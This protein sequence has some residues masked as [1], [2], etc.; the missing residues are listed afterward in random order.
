MKGKFRNLLVGLCG[1]LATLGLAVGVFAATPIMQASAETSAPTVTML[2]GASA[3]KT[4]G[5]P[6]IK[7][8]AKIDNYDKNYQ[9]GMLI[10]PEAAWHALEWDNDTDFIGF[11]NEEGYAYANA[12]CAP[13][14]TD[15]GDWQISF[16]LKNIHEGNYS[17]GFF[18]VAYV[19]NKEAGYTDSE[20]P[21]C[22]IYDYID[23]ADVDMVTN[24]RSIAYVAQMALK[25]ED[26][27]TQEQSNTLTSYAN[28]GLIIE[29][30]D[31]FSDNTIENGGSA[32]ATE[33]N[34]VARFDID[35]VA[36]GNSGETANSF[37]TKEAYA[38]GSEV[39]FKTFI[40]VD[41]VVGGW[42]S[43]CWTTNPSAVNIYAHAEGNGQSLPMTK[44]SWQD[45]SFTLPAG[46]PYYIYF[47]GAKG[48][49]GNYGENGE[50]YVYIDNFTVG[51]TTENFSANTSDWIFA[52]NTPTAVSSYEYQKANII[53]GETA[54]ELSAKIMVNNI[55]STANT[56]SFI[57]AEKYAGGTVTFDYYMSGN[58]NDKWW[59][60]NWTTSN[61]AANIYAFVEPTDT[62]KGVDLPRV[63]DSWQT[64]TVEVPAGNWYFYFAGAVGEWGEGYVLIDNLHIESADYTETF[65]FGLEDSIFKVNKA[66]AIV[67]GEGYVETVDTT[68]YMLVFDE[69]AIGGNEKIAMI[70]DKA[71]SGV[72]EITF[73]AM[74]LN[75][76]VST[77][78]GL[79]YT[80]DPTKFAYD[81]DSCGT[82]YI[83]CYT[84]RFCAL[85]ID[86]GVIYNYRLT[87]SGSSWTLYANDTSLDSGT[88]YEG[89]NYFYFMINPKKGTE[90]AFY[91]DDFSIT[92]ADGTETDTFANGRSALFVESATKNSDHGSSGMSF[93]ESAFGESGGGDAEELGEVALKMYFNNGDDGVRA[94]TSTAY[95]GGSTIQFKYYIQA[96]TATQWT[97]FI[98][99][100]DTSCDNYADTY[101]SF[102]NT[103]GAWVT[104]SYTLPSGGPYYL[105]FGFEC[106]NWKDSSGAPYIL[107]DDFTVNSEVE[108]F[109]YGVENSCFTILQ[110]NLAGNSGLGEGYIPP[111][112]EALGAK[113][114][115]DMISSTANTPSFITSEKYAGG[116][117]TLDYYMSCKT[118]NKW[119]TFNWTTN[120]TVANIY[121][122]VEPT[123][124]NN[125]VSLPVV[126]DSWQTAT[127]EVP[128][129]NW[130][131][132]F[133]GSVGDWGE[134][135]VI[136]DNFY[137]ESADYTETFNNGSYGIF[138]DNRDSKPDA[139]TLVE[140]KEEFLSGEY[141]MKYIF[142]ASGE[143]VSQVTK[144]AYA[145]GSTVSFKY[146][147][148]AGT[149]TKWWG[150]VW[151]TSNRGLDIYAAASNASAY[152]LS[153]TLGEWV[154]VSFTLPAGGPYYLYF[155]SEVG[156]WKLN[157][158][159]AYVLID[160]FKVGDETEDFNKVVDEWAFDVLVD[161]AV[162][163]SKLGEGY[164]E[165]DVEE[166][167]PEVSGNPYD[168]ETL[169]ASGSILAMLKNGGYAWIKTSGTLNATNIPT[170]MVFIEGS[171]SYTFNGEKEFAIWFGNE[172]YLYINAT[173]IALYNDTQKVNSISGSSAAKL[174]LSI[175]AY[176]LDENEEE[177]SSRLILK[178]DNG[179]YIGLGEI[180]EPQE[181]KIVALGGDGSLSLSDIE[182]ETYR[183]SVA[184]IPT[185]FS[186]ESINFTAYAFDSENMISEAG[187]QLLADAGF[188]KTLALLQGRLSTG[189]LHEQDIPNRAHVENL[190]AE[191]NADAMAAVELA[192]KYGLKH[193][194]LNSNLYN[195]ERNPKNYQWLDDFAELA[196]YTLSHAFA[197]H[198]L[199]DEPQ[200][201][202]WF[203]DDEL[204][205]LVNAYK[206][207]KAAFPNS[208]AFINLLP[209]S[210][211]QF[212][213]KESLYEDYI[214]EY[215]EKIALDY[216]G[217]P[218]TG[219]V[220]FDHYP[221]E[222]GG[223]TS[224]HLRNLE[225]IAEKC[226][227]N[228]LELRTYIK[229]SES[230]DSARD[231]RATESINDLYMQIYSALAYGSKEIIYY[232]F[233]DHTK[234]DG[235]VGDAVISGTTLNTMAPVYQYAKQAN[236]EVLAF[237]AAYMNFTWKSASFFGT[238]CKQSD[239]LKSK[240]GVYG[241]LS[242]VAANTGV[243]IG[244]FDD[245][246]SAYTYDA[247][248]GYMVVNYGD[249]Q[250]GTAESGI[251]LTFNGT[252]SRALVYE[253][254]KARVVNLA[255]N[256]LTLN[257][258]VG[259]GAF[260]I[261]LTN[262]Q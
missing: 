222:E 244:N 66:D 105:Y 243:L 2:A 98:W 51:S 25:Y 215:I 164:I 44:G 250:N 160:N 149:E 63:Q 19:T 207:Y 191:V 168:F 187:F 223:I 249:P 135:Y 143:T 181:I 193:Y 225:L 252:P 125:G 241:Y 92:Y 234:S 151:S 256:A 145:G 156:N 121:A 230:G 24:A 237:S 18:G 130:Y 220:S 47:A 23:Y 246:D 30:D 26:Y 248:Y 199:A 129:G 52:V 221:L 213:T 138:L 64:A 74:W 261:P 79:S 133:A 159:N 232:Q 15:N 12:I 203:T 107:I 150:I 173:E 120:N 97:R 153:A 155:G 93:A 109:N 5:E 55:S 65:N 161:G 172:Y 262:N 190:M 71:Y 162:E 211:A 91:L 178:L 69:G 4:P 81:S 80:T 45:V 171:L 100:T 126:Q 254:G 78:W 53:I 123:D 127:V 119:W 214:D 157:G 113:I 43:V 48:E 183:C 239:S 131:F 17:R 198:F 11:F 77:T 33:S 9:Y 147:I 134:G 46:G 206:A 28:A 154:D 212:S 36:D 87:I 196:T 112:P 14:T 242:N 59:T 217:V 169:L 22:F 72:T 170:S 116:T 67:E 38:G 106:G 99:D 115:I 255:S 144:Q 218:G 180:G 257:L 176:G 185:Y 251:R 233:T 189:D 104:W 84:P 219:Y 231:I 34:Y 208:E 229:A 137:I 102:G 124:T 75:S 32:S 16:S 96:D 89:A 140:G 188:T 128:A 68:D 167:E 226:R 110:F 186:T 177:V 10:L 184:D 197:G 56:P 49:W 82:T 41:S 163:L 42:W 216:N 194:A 95:A 8:T 61:T 103:A 57:T 108:T 192:E 158:Q 86:A 258:E 235:S 240:A 132:Y 31:Y 111:E 58:T 60:F 83:N 174:Y 175:T 205:E 76:A 21:D 35:Y 152:P 62:N 13:Y 209:R 39:S 117:V 238:N 247:K 29:K 227:D 200:S 1:V 50:G 73:K 148:P 88:Y 179:E 182:M 165:E 141:A 201:G 20:D 228:G 202:K 3:R 85:K 142:N 136:I 210:S 253:N 224:T 236:N 139:I 6:G 27:L 70:T 118:N 101:T 259:E 122:F 90:D 114:V 195:I 40:P 260:V 146:Y 204:G 7:F 166:Q 245:A 37:V 94:R 54:K